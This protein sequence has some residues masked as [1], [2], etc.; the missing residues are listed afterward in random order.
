MSNDA[1]VVGD[2][3]EEIKEEIS[4]A[5]AEEVLEQIDKE[6]SFRKY[7]GGWA[8]VVAVVATL[9]SLYHLVTSSGVW[10]RP[11]MHH[12]SVHLTFLLILT[13]LLY[14]AFG[15]KKGSGPSYF[16]LAWL[17]VS[18]AASIYI[19]LYFDEFSIRG[20]AI[21][22]DIVMG[23]ILV[24]CVLEA[25]RRSVGKELMI[26]AIVFLAYGLWGDYLPGLLGHTGFSLR[27]IVYQTYLTSEGIFGVALS[28]SATYIFLFILFGAFLAETGMG[29][30]IKDF[31]MC[32]AGRTIGGEAKVAIVTCGLMGMINGSAVGNVAA[33]GTFTIPMMRSAG[34]K[35]VFSAAL[36]AAAG[37][38]G[39][40]MPPVMGAASF[41]MAEYLGM[42]YSRIMLAAAIPAILYYFSQYVF[43]HIEARR[44]GMQKVPSDKITPMLVV[45]RKQGYMIVPIAVIIYLLLIGRTPLYAA[46]YGIMSTLVVTAGAGIFQG[47]LVEMLKSY[48]RAL[49]QGARQSVSVGVACAV[50][51][52]INSI[53]N[54]TGLGFTL[55]SAIVEL[56]AGSIILT[57]FLTM[58]LSIIL[59]MGLP[60]TACYI[61]TAT[62]GAPALLKLGVNPLAAHMFVYYFACLS[63]L[64]PPVAIA[65]YG[66]AGLS[67]Q[68]PSEVGWAGF[69]IALAGFVIPYTFIY[70]PSLLFVG[71]SY[72]EIVTASVTATIGVI[73]AAA[74]VQGYIFAPIN[75]ALRVLLFV[76]ACLLIFPGLSTDLVGIGIFAAMG[77]YQKMQIRASTAV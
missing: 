58:I 59:G 18:A 65:S 26:L 51:G 50:V 5:K 3:K 16:D 15:K 63:N 30:F 70:A 45:L 76:A 8:K 40:I 1:P 7:A 44:L 67:G 9:M 10:I 71:D 20:T 35:P 61:I 12:Q 28:I 52:I 74:A 55:G 38:G 56:A 2:L 77:V 13:F 27:R 62:I 33:T 53:T 6:S 68:N 22:R 21:L 31:A 39:M 66:A 32:L 47:K 54:L 75:M 49:E 46:F 36:V 37:T 17:V 25:T 23:G 11:S 43:V 4:Q 69:R 72:V 24:V 64:T 19:L 48:L 57:A 60:T 41:I 73:A 14:P 29:G 34:F 42:H